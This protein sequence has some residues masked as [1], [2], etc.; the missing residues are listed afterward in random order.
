MAI[1][2]TGSSSE[3]FSLGAEA[4]L[5]WHCLQKRFSAEQIS[6]LNLT[7]VLAK[8]CRKNRTLA[9]LKQPQ[10]LKY[11]P[12]G[13]NTTS[14]K[15]EWLLSDLLELPDLHVWTHESDSFSLGGVSSAGG[16]SGFLALTHSLFFFFFIPV[17]TS[18]NQPSTIL[19]SYPTLRWQI[20]I[21]NCSQYMR[22]KIMSYCFTFCN[23]L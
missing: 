12:A 11:S 6:G 9:L 7:G 8:T 15:E 20:M 14:W 16:L 19:Y 5:W 21:D 2:I 17:K 10:K 1:R 13:G 22:Y 4:L 18:Y 3:P 23:G